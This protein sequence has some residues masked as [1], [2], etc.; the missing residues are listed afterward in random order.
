MRWQDFDYKV[1]KEQNEQFDTEKQNKLL[2]EACKEHT[3]EGWIAAIESGEKRPIGPHV[4]YRSDFD[5]LDVI[6]ST[7]DKIV[8]HSLTP[9][10]TLL[11]SDKT[12][13]IVGVRILDF[14][15]VDGVNFSAEK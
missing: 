13:E 12:D 8:A 1:Y 2:K 10:M 14:S 9:Q 7:D 6:F 15:R 11:L 4:E 5:T 3:L